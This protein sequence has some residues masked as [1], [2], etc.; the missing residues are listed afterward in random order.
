MA[1]PRG[2]IFGA[3]LL[4]S[5]GGLF[6]WA[7]LDPSV[8]PWYLIGRYWPVLIIFWGLGKLVD[9]LSARGTPEGAQA[10]R[11]S[12]GD[13]FLLIFILLIGTAVSKATQRSFW[14]DIG[15]QVEDED[16][17]RWF[18][19]RYEF[20][21]SLEQALPSPATLH[22]T[23]QGNVTLI[24][25]EGARVQGTVR[26]IV[27]APTESEAEQRAQE[28]DVVLEPVPGG[29]PGSYQLRFTV[30][31]HDAGSAR[32]D[33]ELRVPERTS[34]HL[35]SRRG[36]AH[37]EGLT[38]EV[39]VELSRGSAEL[40]SITGPVK[41]ELRRGNAR[42][43][44]VRGNVEV[45]G[46]GNEITVAD[47]QG[48]ARIEGEFV[49]PIR[50]SAISQEARFVSRRTNFMAQRIDG[51]L[52]LIRGDLNVR[53]PAGNI[54]LI[55]EDKDIDL[56]DLEGA[57]RVQNR[58]GLIRLRFPQPPRQPLEAESHSGDIEVVLPA[59]SAF[60][61]DARAPSGEIINQFS[62]DQLTLKEEDGGATL[63]GSYGQRG[64]A[65]R[66]TSRYGSIRLLRATPAGA[67]PPASR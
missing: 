47:V 31:G 43:E 60:T 13:I 30:R 29:P 59:N 25:G 16:W 4:I 14:G 18:G 58:H 42:V 35:E 32:A 39:Q 66:L 45:R 51:E 27:Y 62:G 17:E 65:I 33:L 41:V 24:G 5:I 63:T 67:G 64:P 48:E 34:V 37:I 9:Y 28:A 26:K 11:L 57:V 23:N 55:A 2:S 3:L 36:D 7:N 22:I 20:S 53:R 40:A 46:R 61:I 21:T 50:A 52:E 44:H 6:L 54:T 49:G 8:R 1:A 56:D 38:G 12:G 19:N 10:A 15:V